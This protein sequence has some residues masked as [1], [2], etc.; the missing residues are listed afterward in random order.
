[1]KL[2][3][4]SDL[5]LLPALLTISEVAAV[6]RISVATIRRGLQNGTFHPRPWDKYPYRW[7]REDVLADLDRPRAEQPRRPHGFAAKPRIARAALTTKP[8][9]RSRRT[10]S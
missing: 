5:S 2:A 6:Y 1:M 7:R 4:V 9:S 10:A 3:G 8:R